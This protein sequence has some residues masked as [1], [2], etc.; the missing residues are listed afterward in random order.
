MSIK[1]RLKGLAETFIDSIQC[2]C[3]GHD[4]GE[5]GDNEF[6]T[7]LTRI[8][9]DGIIAVIRCGICNHIFVPIEQRLGI[10]NSERL[11]NAV[12]QDSVKTGQP[13]FSDFKAVVL[14]VERQNAVQEDQVH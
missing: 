2:P 8:T 7:E 1:F 11:R 14:D 4:G 3:C 13:I 5:D 6:H 9:F 10:I 12:E